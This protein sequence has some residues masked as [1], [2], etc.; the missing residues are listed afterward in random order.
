VEPK[1]DIEPKLSV[2]VPA[3]LGYDTVLAALDSWEAQSCRDQL[4]ILVL[5]PT[6]VEA[7]RLQPG[8]VVIVTGS[9][10]LHQARCAGIHQATAD[11]VV[12]AEDHCLPDR[13]WAE[14]ILERLEEGWDAVGPALRSGNPKTI[15][16]QGSF[17]LGYGQWMVPVGGLTHVLPGHNAVLRKKPL[18]ELGAVLERELLVAAFLLRR[19]YG[20]GQRFYLDDRAT[21]RHFDI[22]DWKKNLRIFYCV[23]MGFGAMRTSHW[24]L[25]GRKLYWLAMPAIAV[26]HSMRALTHYR[27]AGARADLSPLCLVASSLFALAWACGESAGALMGVAWVAPFVAASEIKPVARE[28]VSPASFKAK[29]NEGRTC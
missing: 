10:L 28:N 3:L 26:R 21:M 16:T 1:A 2:I 8:Q 14:A 17:L 4:E 19:L 5:C 15:W 23:G 12:L 18:L 6:P 25:M 27:R 11:Y 24:P 7:G 20:Q 29:P 13:F 9:L 22:P